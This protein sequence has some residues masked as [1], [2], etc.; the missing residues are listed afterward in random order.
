M[1]ALPKMGMGPLSKANV[2]G[3]VQEDSVDPDSLGQ[4]V[5]S[6]SGAIMAGSYR[7]RQQAQLWEELRQLH[8]AS[9]IPQFHKG[10]SFFGDR[11]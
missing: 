11:Y 4:V 7:T 1:W 8:D 3:Q 5:Q 2:E 6:E 9:Q 10:G